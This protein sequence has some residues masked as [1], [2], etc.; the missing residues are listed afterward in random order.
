MFWVSFALTLALAAVAITAGLMRKRKLHL[1]AGPA[2]IALLAVTVVLTERLVKTRDFP[3]EE[4]RIHLW[5]AKSGGVLALLVAV[6]GIL[7][8][9]R[10][11]MRK[12]HLAMVV[13][14]LLA[15]VAATGTGIWVFDL[16]SPK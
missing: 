11:G 8:V 6:T 4:L 16:S 7:L 12:V 15:T 9:F 1:L 2:T 3:A 14:F 10:P 5:F 13:L